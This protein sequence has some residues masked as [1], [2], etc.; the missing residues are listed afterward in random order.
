M[1]SSRYNDGIET[2]HGRL[3]IRLDGPQ[4]G[5]PLL[6]LQRFRGTMDDWDLAFIAAIARD[7]RVIRLTVPALEDRRAPCRTPSAGWQSSLRMS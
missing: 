6:L 5:I 4:G 1:F 7:R 3:A 2:S